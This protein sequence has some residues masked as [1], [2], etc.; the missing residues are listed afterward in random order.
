MPRNIVTTEQ[1]KNLLI[2]YFSLLPS[3]ESV[4]IYSQSQIISELSFLENKDLLIDLASKFHLSVVRNIISYIRYIALLDEN[5]RNTAIFHSQKISQI[6][7][8]MKKMQFETIEIPNLE[9]MSCISLP[10]LKYLEHFNIQESQLFKFKKTFSPK[11]YEFVSHEDEINYVCESICKLIEKGI[12]LDNIYIANLQP[13]F[14][15]TFLRACHLFNIPTNIEV[16]NT[17]DKNEIGNYFLELLQSTD[18]FVNAL[19]LLKDKYGDLDIYDSIHN[20]IVTILNAYNLEK[21]TPNQLY[22]FIKEDFSNFKSQQKNFANSINIIETIDIVNL[23]D[24]VHVFIIGC[25]FEAFP[26]V[27]KDSDYFT[28][29]EKE[30]INY[31]TSASVNEYNR[32]MI[33]QIICSRANIILTFIEHDYNS[34]YYISEILPSSTKLDNKLYVYSNYANSLKF[35]Q[36]LDAQQ[37]YDEYK[38]KISINYNTYDSKFNVPLWVLETTVPPLSYST[39]KT[40]N[41]CPYRFYIEHFLLENQEN[42][43]PSE[44]TVLGNV[45]HE[46]LA[47]LQFGKV[48]SENDKQKIINKIL[49]PFP[50]AETLKFFVDLND[51][52][53]QNSYNTL[54]SFVAN[55]GYNSLLSETKYSTKIDSVVI[56]GTIDCILFKVV[57]DTVYL[58]IFDFKSGNNDDITY[59]TFFDKDVLNLQIPTYLYL[60]END[61]K[62]GFSDYD[63][64]Y[65]FV[66]YYPLYLDTP[67]LKGLYSDDTYLNNSEVIT[68]GRKNSNSENPRLIDYGVISDLKDLFLDN[69]DLVI[70][71]IEKNDFP[72]SPFIEKKK[73]KREGCDNCEF[74]RICNIEFA[75]IFSKKDDTYGMD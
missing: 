12:D 30:L 47:N 55:Q 54:M 57:N 40:F 53:F 59:D 9:Y 45:W 3:L 61:P 72:I 75:D 14:Y 33:Q 28:D 13:K 41:Q 50:N 66:G 63:F 17:L 43:I 48:L 4:K 69:L 24:D 7:S 22:E 15:P 23:P 70:G 29:L 42:Y 11:V 44:N 5:K 25:N 62:K 46:Y 20:Q 16:N 31:P 56:K 19:D 38:N 74:K 27:L 2:S 18:T 73:N 49:K 37:S 26:K 32:N 34:E 21:Y 35:A 8:Y 68:A 65:D 6:C 10:S 58:S 67:K 51:P 60:L 39:I 64:E 1:G 36:I 52:V 71:S